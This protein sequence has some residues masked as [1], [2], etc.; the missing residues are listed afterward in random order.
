MITKA[1]K[2]NWLL[3]IVLQTIRWPLDSNP[4]NWLLPISLQMINWPPNLIQT[5]GLY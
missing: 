4:K 5:I 3:L 2:K 1:Q